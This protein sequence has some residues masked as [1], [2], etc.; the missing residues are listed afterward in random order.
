MTVFASRRSLFRMG[1]AGAAL[2]AAPRLTSSAQAAPAPVGGEPPAFYRFKLGDFEVTTISDGVR[3]ATGPYPIFGQNQSPTTVAKLMED[4]FLPTDRFANGFT[5]TLVN[6]GGDLILFDTGMGEA[7]RQSGMGRLRET[8]QASGYKPEDVSIVMLTHFHGDHIGGMTEGGKPAFPNARYVA[9]Q[10]EYDFWTDAKQAKGPS[11]ENAKLIAEKIVPLKDKFTL[12]KDGD[13]I[14]P[15]ITA[16]A[17]PGH[18][19]GHTAF[20]LASKKRLL[21]ITAD[22]ANHY[23]ASLQ[24]PAWHVQ[25]DADKEQATATRRTIFDFVAHKR[26]PFI[27]YHMPFP[28]VGYVEKIDQG[29]RYMPATYQF[30]V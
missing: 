3:V 8:M 7:A 24:R 4:N 22:T 16:M 11:E 26:M 15:G 9:S 13:E 29:Y 14:V 18:T 12:V 20:M 30:E 19:P 10:I 2:A 6:T 27:G 5:P 17:A 21:L 28:A 23:V 25:Y 1:V